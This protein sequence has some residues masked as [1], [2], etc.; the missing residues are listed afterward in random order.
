MR[1]ILIDP[2]KR[3]VT[4]INLEPSTLQKIY[5]VMSCDCIAC[6]V[7][8]ENGDD[9]YLDDEGI[10]KENIDYFIFRDKN[11]GTMT[12][13]GKC[14]IIGHN[15]EGENI[16]AVSSVVEIAKRISFPIKI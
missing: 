13:V 3:K 2:E 9:L 7:A 10:Y 6:P 8:L 16:D 15:K 1:A 14:L 12:F 5:E 4:E 11:Y